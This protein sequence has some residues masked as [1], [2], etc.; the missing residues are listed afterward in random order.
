[1]TDSSTGE[2]RTN[3]RADGIQRN[4]N[5]TNAKETAVQGSN[6]KELTWEKFSRLSS[7]TK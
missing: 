6:R 1:M 2:T 7:Q 4:A 3:R 5:E